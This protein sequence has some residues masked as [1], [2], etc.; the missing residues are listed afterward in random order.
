MKV[1]IIITFNPHSALAY[2]RGR[3]NNTESRDPTTRIMQRGVG[4]DASSLLMGADDNVHT[5]TYDNSNTNIR[6]ESLRRILSRLSP[7]GLFKNIE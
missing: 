3:M 2:G 1:D 7:S 5:P 4:E 6:E